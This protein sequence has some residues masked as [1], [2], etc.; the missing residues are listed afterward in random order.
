VIAADD[1][2]RRWLAGALLLGA[3]S[4]PSFWWLDHPLSLWIAQTLQAWAV[5]DRA[6]QVPDQLLLLVG[7]L[8][9]LSW[10]AYLRWRSDQAHSLHARLG[11]LVG[12]ML[13]LAFALKSGLKWVFGRTETHAWLAGAP[14]AFHWFAGAAGTVGFPSGH[15]L[16]LSPLFMACWQYWPRYRVVCGAAWLGLAVAL[17]VTQYHFLSD[18]LAGTSIGVVIHVL[19]ARLLEVAPRPSAPAEPQAAGPIR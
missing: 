5:Y 2:G 18:V 3:A 9:G 10:L 6:T 13:P 19:A 8:T 4:A 11:R 15:M 7:V 12:T 1:P 14:D 17:M 16:V